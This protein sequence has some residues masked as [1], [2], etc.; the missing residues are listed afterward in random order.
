MSHQPFEDWLL[1]GDT[2]SLE[3]HAS[4]QEHL[5]SCPD[6]RLLSVNW[7]MAYRLLTHAPLAAPEP[8]FALRWQQLFSARQAR[9]HSFIFLGLAFS[10]ALLTLAMLVALTWPIISAPET[11]LYSYLYQLMQFVLLGEMLNN[12][13]NGLA[14]SAPGWMPIVGGV[15]FAGLVCQLAVIWLVSIR[16]LTRPRRVTNE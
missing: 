7:Q 14:R 1:N 11:L 5:V 3:Q 6:C 12:F 9:R 4:L 13:V 16:V 10:A 8:G 15:L 2:L